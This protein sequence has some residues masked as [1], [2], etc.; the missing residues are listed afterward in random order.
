[1]DQ[2]QI[3]QQAI[4][5]AF[6][7]FFCSG[8]IRPDDALVLDSLAVLMKKFPDCLFL[9]TV[10]TDCRADSAYNMEFSTQQAD[11]ICVYLQKAGVGK[12]LRCAGRGEND[13]V[14]DCRCEGTFI[15]KKCTEEEHE[16]NRR[17]RLRVV[18]RF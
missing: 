12:N 1:M 3:G 18:D 13:P 10:H 16:Q 4:I 15:A 17:T 9:L 2:P 6:W 14:N 7:N 8:K 11:S 5:P